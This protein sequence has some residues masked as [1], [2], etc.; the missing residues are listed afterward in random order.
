VLSVQLIQQPEIKLNLTFFSL[1][2]IL[3]YGENNN[4]QL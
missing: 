2:L 1:A 4:T 3:F